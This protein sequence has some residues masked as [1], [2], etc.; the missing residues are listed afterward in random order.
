MTF[1]LVDLALFVALLATTA[2]V[3]L[4]YRRLRAM[5]RMLA[6]YQAASEA[7]AR[8]L[9]NA[10]QAVAVLNT[11]TRTLITALIARSSEASGIL[12]EIGRE[13]RRFQV[14]HDSRDVIPLP[15][16]S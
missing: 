5:N 16:R 10:V 6:E 13:R 1:S 2:S 7:T 8:A 14:V 3:L 9:D 12:E 11:E 4:V 15:P